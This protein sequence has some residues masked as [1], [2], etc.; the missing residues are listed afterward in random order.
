MLL[1]KCGKEGDYS[2]YLIF[3]RNI[4]NNENLINSYLIGA[5]DSLMIPIFIQGVETNNYG[6]HKL[7]FNSNDDYI[8]PKSYNYN[9]FSWDYGNTSSTKVAPKLPTAIKITDNG[10]SAVYNINYSATSNIKY[11]MKLSYKIVN[12]RII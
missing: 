12:K 4:I 7:F 10:T 11:N 8:S 3:N 2:Y 9:L 1:N 5:S 6:V